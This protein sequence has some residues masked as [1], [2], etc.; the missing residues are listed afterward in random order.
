MLTLILRAPGPVNHPD[1]FMQKFDW[2][3]G[4]YFPRTLTVLIKD[5]VAICH[6][7]EIQVQLEISHTLITFGIIPNLRYDFLQ[8]TDKIYA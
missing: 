4:W 6:Q 5:F 8:V 1:I 7:G 3:P 2:T